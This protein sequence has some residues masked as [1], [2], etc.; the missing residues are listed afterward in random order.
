MTL[1][2]VVVGGEE[3]TAVVELADDAV[4]AWEI[5]VATTVNDPGSTSAVLLVVRRVLIPRSWG[6]TFLRVVPFCCMLVLHIY[7]EDDFLLPLASCLPRVP[8]V[9]VHMRY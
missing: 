9:L 8:L 6:R 7:T 5:L 4:S 1:P 3:T 2:V